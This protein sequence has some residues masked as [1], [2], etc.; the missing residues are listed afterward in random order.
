LAPTATA[1]GKGFVLVE[2]VELNVAVGAFAV[3]R[4]STGFRHPFSQ[5]L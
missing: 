4:V 5:L 3:P 1:D 2:D